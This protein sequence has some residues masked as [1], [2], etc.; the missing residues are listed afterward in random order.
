MVQVI[1][2]GAGG[3]VGPYLIQHIQ[4]TQPATTVFGSTYGLLES[5]TVPA[6]YHQID[7]KDYDA[8]VRWLDDTQPDVVYHLAGQS[9]PSKA[10]N[11]IWQTLE[12]NIRI[13]LN[14]LQA[15]VDLK[16]EPRII[17]I[18][19]GDIYTGGAS[20]SDMMPVNELS[21]LRPSNPYALSKVTQDLMGL[22]YFLS[23]QLPVIRVRPFNH[24][25]P[26]QRESFV[27]PDF[28]LQIAKIEAS[29]QEPLMRVGNLEAKRDF[30]D[31]RD[32]VRAYAL[33]AEHGQA[34]DSYNVSSNKTYSIQSLL[35]TLL[36]Y[37]DADIKVEIDPARFRPVDVPIVQGDNTKLV[38]LTGWQPT[39]T[40]EQTLHDLL[41]DCRER[42]QIMMRS[43]Q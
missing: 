2:T 32:V 6:N 38:E 14:L 12:T 16:I 40:F 24:T 8:V 9:S 37:T 1:V 22:Q 19:S 11:A 27:A 17:S 35:D 25:G 3:F 28:A 20:H 10:L 34:G 31:V 33:L 43:K 18:S 26:K 30:T 4:A 21:E 23:Y 15:C 7:L 5:P 42:V 39:I 41:N 29:L 36:S 13:Q